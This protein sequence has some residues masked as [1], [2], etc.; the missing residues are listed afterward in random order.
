VESTAEGLPPKGYPQLYSLV[1]M[2]SEWDAD[3][4][5][6]PPS[7]GKH[8]S[9]R[10]FDYKTQFAE[11]TLYRE[12]EVPFV[13]RGIP[14]LDAAVQKWTE[15]YLTEAFGKAE[16]MVEHSKNNHHMFYVRGAHRNNPAFKPP[17][18]DVYMPFSSWLSK[19]KDIG[20]QI[21]AQTV[22]NTETEHYYFRVSSP[23]FM[24][25]GKLKH[26]AP[27]NPMF[28]NHFIG[29]DL[30]IFHGVPSLFIVDQHGQRGIH[31][32]FGM[33]GVIAEC[34][35][36]SGRNFIALMRGM[37]RYILS[38]PTECDNLGLLKKGPS[39]RH[40]FV[41]WGDVDAVKKHMTQSKAVEVIV[42]AGDSLYIPAGW[43][44]HIISLSLNYQC[45]SRSGNPEMGRAELQK[46][47]FTIGRP[48]VDYESKHAARVKEAQAAF[49]KLKPAL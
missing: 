19:A 45:N 34:H 48:E 36:D 9:L 43:F 37:K 21:R 47:G 1:D 2:L 29:K 32:R 7:Y 25:G 31:C 24:P 3:D 40:T 41:D 6:I 42:Q 49:A 5:F 11:A 18:E 33:E 44:H 14:S 16:K 26:K 8:H 10:V 23:E 39:A 22:N 17:T 4:I 15:E 20:G 28:D 30:E 46:C 13:V 35:Y 38:P 27:R 12:M